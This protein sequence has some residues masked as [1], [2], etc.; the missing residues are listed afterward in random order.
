MCHGE[1]KSDSSKWAYAF[2]VAASL[3]VIGLAVASSVL[4]ATAS[5]CTV[6]AAYGAPPRSVTYSD[7]GPFVYLVVANAI[8]AFLVAIAV[9]FSVWNKKGKLG[10]V[11]SKIMPV[12]GA[13]VPALLYTST[14]AA[15]AARDG[16]MPNTSAYGKRVSVCAANVAGGNFC[17]QVRLAIFLSLGAAVTV[18]LIELVKSFAL[19]KSSGGGSDS[20]SDSDSDFCGYGCHSKH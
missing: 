11:V 18:T 3:A 8:A 17:R 15:F 4:M 9:F 1:K 16:M 12:L 20:D 2:V 5:Q 13:A 19:S 14:A 6:Y 7:F 10:G